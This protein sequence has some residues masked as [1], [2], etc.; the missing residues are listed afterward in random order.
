MILAGISQIN[1]SAAKIMEIVPI[2]EKVPSP[3]EELRKPQTPRKRSARVPCS[4]KS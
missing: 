2:L 4:E 3:I 1:A